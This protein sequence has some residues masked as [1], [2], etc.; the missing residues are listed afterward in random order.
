MEYLSS[1]SAIKNLI[2]TVILLTGN[3]SNL[4]VEGKVSYFIYSLFF[5][6]DSHSDRDHGKIKAICQ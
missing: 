6:S 2:F 5:L 4:R 1:P 3:E